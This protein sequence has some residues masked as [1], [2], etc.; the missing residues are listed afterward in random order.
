VGVLCT[1]LSLALL[2]GCSSSLPRPPAGR[3]P[4][5]AMTQEV[6]YPPPP[7]R[8]EVIPPK[9]GERDVWI[10]GQWD[11]D[12]QA[13]KWLAGQWMTPPADAYF[14]PWTAARRGDGRLFFAPAAWRDKYG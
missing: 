1:G 11:W 13:W 2:S 14:T 3:V 7:A 12:G 8:V 6:P 9:K 4:A 10:D 5:D